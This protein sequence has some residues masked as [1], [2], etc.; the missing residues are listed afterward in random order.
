MRR[1][2]KEKKSTADFS[3]S[4]SWFDTLNRYLYYIHM[5]NSVSPGPARG[6]KGREEEIRVF[7]SSRYRLWIGILV[8]NR[9]RVPYVH[10]RVS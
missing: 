7:G 4:S 6:G 3:S 2:R 1:K 5:Q 9:R 8:G 10:T